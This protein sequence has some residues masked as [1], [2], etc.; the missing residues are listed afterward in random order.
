MKTHIH[1][2]IGPNETTSADSK[3]LTLRLTWMVLT[4]HEA[5]RM[6]GLIAVPKMSVDVKEIWERSLMQRS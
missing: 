5:A 1:W 4:F 2:R 3:G 6:G